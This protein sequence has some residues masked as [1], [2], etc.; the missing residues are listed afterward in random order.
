MTTA[1]LYAR[2]ST[3]EQA[4][5]GYSLNDQ[6]ES[7]R[8]RL[9]SQ[10]YANIEQY[11]DDGYSGE[12][13]DRPALSKLRNDLRSNLVNIVMVYDP[14]R[15]SRNLTNQL[16]IAD[17]I[18]KYGAKLDFITGSYDASPE[19]RLFF[20]M[21]GAIAEFEKEKIRERSLRGKRAKVLSGKP[22]FSKEPFGYNC[23]RVNGIYI[24]NKEEAEIVRTIFNLYTEK[25]YS[26]IKLE[27]ELKL[28]GI[29]NKNGK[30]FH[31]AVLHNILSN[32]MY[33]GTKWSFKKY[34]KNIGQHKRKTITRDQSE[35]VALSIPAIIKKEVFDKATL[36]RSRNKATSKR[37]T[38]GQYLLQNRI[39]CLLCNHKLGAVTFPV[40]SNGKCYSYYVCSKYKNGFPCKNNKSINLLVLDEAVWKD[41]VS[42]FKKHG[43]ITSPKPTLN[44]V[45]I[46][47]KA[48]IIKLNARKSALIKWVGNGTIGPT[49]AEQE[50]Q[51][52]NSELATLQLIISTPDPV[53]KPSEVTI[54]E[55]LA[56][57]TFEE[58][59]TI[60]LRLNIIIHA[61]KNEK[62]EILYEITKQNTF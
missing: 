3:T 40:K 55:I 51:K 16:I 7:C 46:N 44:T 4:E 17:E 54:D 34:K 42:I 48:K 37:N 10:G 32:E 1:A 15:L 8:Q 25:Q 56:A 39:R 60:M 31:R 9:L 50:L 49:D 58:K 45:K 41:I 33:A 2:V 47:A 12:F 14:D 35:W 6:I 30:P 24:I 36:I 29:V 57:N 11:I 61:C 18:D 5:H 26:T 62:G 19:G 20:S 52:L 22:L 53:I 28:M 23:D 21:R 38:K 27:A 59:R 13:I 43:N